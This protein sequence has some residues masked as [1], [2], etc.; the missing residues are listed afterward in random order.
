MQICI[1]TYYF[2]DGIIVLVISYTNFSVINLSISLSRNHRNCSEIHD[3]LF[4]SNLDEIKFHRTIK[5]ISIV[6]FMRWI[7]IDVSL[8][9][10]P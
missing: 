4:Q 7:Y 9:I 2:S 10:S 6:A 3:V 5:Y 8:Q 1:K